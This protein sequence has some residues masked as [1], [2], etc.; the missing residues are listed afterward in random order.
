M[1]KL[2]REINKDKQYIRRDSIDI[3]GINLAVADD[4]IEDECL[5]ILKTAKVKIGNKFPTAMDI[6]AAHRKRNKNCVIVKFVNRKFA[7]GSISKR[8][9]LRETDDYGNIYINSSL[10]PEFAFLNFAVR[11][12]KR[13]KEIFFYKLKNGITFIQMEQNSNFIEISH[14]NDLVKN[15]I[16]VPTR[17]Y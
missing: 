13:N 5:K 4:D 2:E 16:T 15:G 12:A 10:C 3:V 8:D 6:Q 7:F 11:K 1:E 14:V 9:N 17:S